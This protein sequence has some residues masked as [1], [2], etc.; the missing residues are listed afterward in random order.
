MTDS[1]IQDV[2]VRMAMHGRSLFERGFTVGSSGNLSARVPNGFLVTPTNSCLG[3]LDPSRISLLD[4]DWKHLSGDL[5]SK[6]LPLHRAMYETRPQT[7]AVVHLH[8]TYATALSMLPGIK[9]DDALPAITPYAVM[10]VGRLALIPYT[11]PGSEAVIAHIQALQG[12]HKAVLLGNHGPVV[13]DSSLDDAVY[14]AEELEETCK[15]VV[16]TQGMKPRMLSDA[17]VADLNA[18][19]KM[20]R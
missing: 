5:P 12:A 10:R 16:L 2:R 4:M 20:S 15:L 13:A 17:D 7:E 8:S 18:T 1:A 14:A 6:E 19:L 9:P 3:R 11:K